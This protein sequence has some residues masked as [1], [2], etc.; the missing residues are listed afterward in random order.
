MIGVDEKY[1]WSPEKASDSKIQIAG[2][3][4][5][6]K[7]LTGHITR[8]VLVVCAQFFVQM[9][10]IAIYLSRPKHKKVDWDCKETH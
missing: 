10:M 9:D 7:K 2:S 3:Y 8:L 1:I 5:R 4:G 6:S